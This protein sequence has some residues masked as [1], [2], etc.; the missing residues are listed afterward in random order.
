ME[1]NTDGWILNKKRNFSLKMQKYTDQWILNKN[2][3]FSLKKAGKY[4][5]MDPNEKEAVVHSKKQ[6]YHDVEML[7]KRQKLDCN[8]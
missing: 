4:R 8:K 2:R 1:K 5:S 6:K 3:N 7:V